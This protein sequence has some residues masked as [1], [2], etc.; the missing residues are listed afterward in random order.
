MVTPSSSSIARIA[1]DSP[2][3]VM[4]HAWAAWP[5]WPCLCRADRYRI[6]SN[7]FTSCLS[8]EGLFQPPFVPARRDQLDERVDE[9]AQVRTVL[10]REARRVLAEQVATWQHREVVARQIRGD[11]GDDAD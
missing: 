4:W 3:C 9:T 6:D 1:F 10:D 11:T 5:K 8:A 2:G 7:R